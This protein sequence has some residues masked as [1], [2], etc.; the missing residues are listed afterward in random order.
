MISDWTKKLQITRSR[1]HWRKPYLVM[2]TSCVS[3]CLNNARLIYAGS[4]LHRS[5]I[6]GYGTA[7][8]NTPIP[9]WRRWLFC[10]WCCTANLCSITGTQVE[11]GKQ[12]LNLHL[13]TITRSCDHCSFSERTCMYNSLTWHLYRKRY[14]DRGAY[15]CSRTDVTHVH[16]HTMCGFLS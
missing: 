5:L 11:S 3:L 15:F 14:P 10:V 16:C 2:L 6:N 9:F 4:R 13:T 8:H 7:F 1:V 12:W